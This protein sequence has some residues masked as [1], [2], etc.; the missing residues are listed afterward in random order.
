MENIWH[1]SQTARRTAYRNLKEKMPEIA[2][3]NTRDISIQTLRN[4]EYKK[5]YSARVKK[6][7]KSHNIKKPFL[8]HTQSM[9][10]FTENSFNFKHSKKLW[11]T[12][13]FEILRTLR[14]GLLSKGRG[15]VFLLPPPSPPPCSSF[16]RELFYPLWKLTS[17]DPLPE[18]YFCSCWR[19]SCP[20]QSANLNYFCKQWQE[21]FS[22]KCKAEMKTPDYKVDTLHTSVRKLL[23]PIATT[24]RSRSIL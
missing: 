22:S 16:P 13:I 7:T 11:K 8:K 23:C 12:C 15:F 5:M 10:W 20:H 21:Y 3:R 6:K 9:D 18:S 4:T 24:F 1:N 14:K 17:Y 2:V 19:Y